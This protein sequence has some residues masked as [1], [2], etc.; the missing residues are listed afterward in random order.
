MLEPTFRDDYS[1]GP[2]GGD[3]QYSHFSRRDLATAGGWALFL[4]IVS[5][6]Y[7][8]YNLYTLLPA[9][10]Y[11]SYIGA[12]PL[13]VMLSMLGMSAA[14]IYWYFQFY[15]NS[16]AIGEGSN[17]PARS[18][19]MTSAVLALFRLWGVLMII[20]TIY[21]IYVTVLGVNLLL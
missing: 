9:I 8:L 17:N 3:S 5:L 14:I 21:T 15:N 2:S 7:L 20:I 18:H 10:T 13:L 16:R 12:G 4:A 6:L 19:K 11:L 1:A